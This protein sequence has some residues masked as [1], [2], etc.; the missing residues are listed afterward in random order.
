MMTNTTD[1]IYDFLTPD[2]AAVCRAYQRAYATAYDRLH[3]RETDD[4]G[5]LRHWS[6]LAHHNA[7]ARLSKSMPTH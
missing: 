5:L 7:L 1:T 4:L 6:D 3:D 2:E